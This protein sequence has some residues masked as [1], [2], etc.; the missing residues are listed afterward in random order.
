[1]SKWDELSLRE[2][3]DMISVAVKNG[4]T[5]LKDIQAK[6]NEFAEGGSTEVV[7]TP[8]KEYTL[9]LNTL[10]DNQRLTPNDKYDSYSYWKLN[11]KPKNFQEAIDRGMFHF[12]NSDNA[13]HANSVAFGEDGVGYFMKPKNHSTVRYETD[14]FNKGLVTEEGGWQRP[15][16]FLEW[17]ESQP[18]REEYKLVDDP[19][20]PNYYKYQP[21][22]KFAT[23]GSTKDDDLIDWIIREEGFNTKPED[24][25]DGKMTLGSGLTAQKWHDLYKKKGNK[26]SDQD[27]RRAVAEEVA[28]R[29]RWAEKTI[30]NWDS[31]P[32]SSQKA[33][34]SYKYNYDFTP[35]NSPKLFQAL[36]DS[37]LK[38]VARQMDATSKNS[39]FKKGLQARRQ[40]EQEWFLSGLPT[41]TPQ[42]PM[43]FEQSISTN[44]SN[45]YRQQVENT[46]IAPEMV[47]DEASYVKAHKLTEAED[48][49]N[50]FNKR[51]EAINNF[52]RMMQLIA[53][54]NNE[55]APYQSTNPLM[56]YVSSLD[57]ANADGGKIHIKPSHRGRLTELKKRT[58]K[59]EAELYNDGN[60]AHK[61]M[62]VFARNSRKWHH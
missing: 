5:N 25:G 39:K 43:F 9:Y 52:N 13:Y 22:K 29:R 47:P 40:R 8:D 34:L 54:Q 35:A 20:R 12:D 28:N 56:D 10:P 14:W 44:V 11:G 21:K 26:W 48:R 37:N 31:L 50:K 55:V 3:A 60:P 7:I 2:K 36:K 51:M 17:K 16:T 18:F 33:L 41:S 46:L 57:N 30:P 6:Y 45:P 23:G 19:T 38:E 15:E 27:N 4:F 32:E 24:I 1:M 53:P 49:V 42:I 62:V 61:K 58:G 59:S